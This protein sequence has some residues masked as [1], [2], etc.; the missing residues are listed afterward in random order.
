M[1]QYRTHTC[2]ELRKEQ[3]G[4]TVR[5]SGWVNTIR[6]HGGV[7]F[8]DLRDHYGIAQVVINPDKEFYKDIEHWRVE[9]VLC[10]TGEIVA[11]DDA[12]INPKL[13]TGEIELVAE[14]MQ[15][16]GE[17]KVIPFQVNK[18]EECNEALRLQ[19]RFLDLRRE[20]L[21]KNLVLR[22]KVIARIR[23]LMTAE[24]FME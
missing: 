8:I 4:Q 9:T 2:G 22:S 7:L 23:E 1:H 3:V 6:D 20:S 19:Y 15:V 12:A 11:R 10:F 24:G 16:L 18:E 21:H 13:P 5:I 17:S 14:T